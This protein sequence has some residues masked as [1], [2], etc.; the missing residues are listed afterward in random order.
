MPALGQP[1]EVKAA[2]EV[3]RINQPHLL[4]FLF[5]E[6]QLAQVRQQLVIAINPLLVKVG[7]D[8]V[9]DEA[10]HPMDNS[11]HLLFLLHC[12]GTIK[13]RV[14]ILILEDLILLYSH[15]EPSFVGSPNHFC[16]L[17]IRGSHLRVWGLDWPILR[18]F[19]AGLRITQLA[20]EG[21]REKLHSF[22]HRCLAHFWPGRNHSLGYDVFHGHHRFALVVKPSCRQLLG[23]ILKGLTLQPRS[24]DIAQGS[25]QV[26]HSK[27]LSPCEL[28]GKLQ[29]RPASVGLGPCQ[30]VQGVHHAGHSS[31]NPG[32]FLL[33]VPLDR[34]RTDGK[35]VVAPQIL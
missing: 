35:Q 30:E 2:G 28:L 5:Q 31:G 20:S 24:L 6:G 25:A 4:L 14:T 7:W 29:V 8:Q 13:H 10:L 21:L 17:L 3:F 1:E 34:D 11:I 18:W 16:P 12:S 19:Q 23:C 22:L 15:H 32:V 26:L 27:F 9:A 33:E